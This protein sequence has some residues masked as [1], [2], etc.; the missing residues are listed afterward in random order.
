MAVPKRRT[1]EAG[2]DTDDPSGRRKRP[3]RSRHRVDH[4]CRR[5]VAAVKRVTF[6]LTI[7]IV[8]KAMPQR[9]LSKDNSSRVSRTPFCPRT[10]FH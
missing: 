2:H 1:F 5:L 7:G 4:R 3:P 10:G 9:P 6:L 8:T